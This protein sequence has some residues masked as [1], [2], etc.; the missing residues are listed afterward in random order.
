MSVT[1][2]PLT[3]PDRVQ[4]STSRVKSAFK[5]REV[6]SALKNVEDS[7]RRF[8]DD[9]GNKIS[10]IILSSNVT[11]GQSNPVD[12]GVAVWFDWHGETR[13]IA[14][15]RYAKVA[16]NLQ[17][18]H[19]IIEA[20]RTELRHGGLTIVKQTFAGFIALPAPVNWRQVL[21]FGNDEKV[22]SERV[23][24]AHRH[25]AFQSHPDRGGSAE[26]MAELNLARDRALE[27]VGG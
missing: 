7:L 13:C 14:V 17:A 27:E 25:L 3:W 2:Y 15:D 6:S 20:R 1:A 11:L 26:K 19:H 24:D 18:I 16:E 23:K 10:N 21:G 22:T 12:P 4:R 5:P 8:G 9:S